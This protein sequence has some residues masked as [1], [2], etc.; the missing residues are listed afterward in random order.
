MGDET[1]L[2]N[3]SLVAEMKSRGQ[4]HPPGPAGPDPPARTRR[5]GPARP[6]PP[7]RTD[8]PGPAEPAQPFSAS[9]SFTRAPMRSSEFS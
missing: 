1:A 2:R 8:R 7:A 3:R 9:D 6:D 5:P 4:G